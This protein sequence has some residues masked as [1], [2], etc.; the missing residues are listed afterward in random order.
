MFVFCALFFIIMLSKLKER[1]D[2]VYRAVLVR[3]YLVVLG[4]YGAVPVGTWWYWVSITLYCLERTTNNE[5]GKMD[6]GR[7]R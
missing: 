2:Q 3:S 4:Q 1:L 5:E 7:L 6:D